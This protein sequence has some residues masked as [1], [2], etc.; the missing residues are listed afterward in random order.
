MK[1][2]NKVSRWSLLKSQLNNLDPDEFRMAIEHESNGVLIDCRKPQEVAQGKIPGAINIDYLAP[3]FW[4][5]IEQLDAGQT[6]FVY[7]RSGRRSIRT[8][9][10]MENGGF[11]RVFNLDGGLNAWITYFGVES[12]INEDSCLDEMGE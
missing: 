9:T 3:D 5:Q 1:K 6:Y 7:C 8:C 2:N 11:T 12:L 10:L 4:E